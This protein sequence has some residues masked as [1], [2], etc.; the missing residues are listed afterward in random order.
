MA[1]R[2]IEDIDARLGALTKPHPD[3]DCLYH[4]I[5]LTADDDLKVIFGLQ[6]E[7]VGWTDETRKHELRQ[8]RLVYSDFV[9]IWEKIGQ[10]YAFI[11][12]ADE[13]TLFLLGGG[14]ALVEKELAESVFSNL[15]KPDPVVNVGP[16]GFRSRDSFDETAFRRAP[17][18]R[19][20]MDVLKRDDRRCRICGRRPDDNSDLELHIHHIRPWA[21]GGITDTSNL[22]T[23]CHTCHNGLMPHED[24]SLYQYITKDPKDPLEAMLIGFFKEVANYRKVGFFGGI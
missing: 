24:H 12:T 20:R 15:L 8:S 2:D 23:L 1:H 5:T 16:V 17:T 3:P 9:T 4:A 21:K 19:L 13:L 11:H 6:T 18:P 14:N 22:I 10:P 7:W